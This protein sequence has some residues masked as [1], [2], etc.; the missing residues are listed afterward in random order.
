[1]VAV[2]SFS[3]IALTDRRSQREEEEKEEEEKEEVRNL[4]LQPF[5]P[6]IVNAAVVGAFIH[7]DLLN[8]FRDNITKA[9]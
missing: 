5:V 1:M 6:G 2:V 4:L 8:F 3:S 7:D 9:I